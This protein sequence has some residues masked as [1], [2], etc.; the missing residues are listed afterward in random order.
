MAKSRTRVSQRDLHKRVK[1]ML[2]KARTPYMLYFMEKLP[3]IKSELKKQKLSGQELHRAAVSELGKRWNDLGPE[4]KELWQ[5]R[6]KAEF[7]HRHEATLSIASKSEPMPAV[8]NNCV[9]VGNWALSDVV[10]WQGAQSTAY[11]ATHYL[12]L[13]E[14]LAVLY[15]D[16][17]DFDSEV[18]M[19]KELDS[20]RAR[21]RKCLFLGIVQA[22]VENS[23][24]HCIIYQ[25]LP[26]IEDL[27]KQGGWSGRKLEVVGRQLALALDF[28][29][30]GVGVYHCNIRPKAVH[31]SDV[32]KCVK[33]SHMGSVRRCQDSSKL[34]MAP[35]V[36]NYR[37][38][39]LWQAL[40]A[41]EV[42]ELTESWAFGCT[43][44]EIGSGCRMFDTV[45]AI[46]NFTPTREKLAHVEALQR[47]GVGVAR[48]LVQFLSSPKERLCLKHFLASEALL[49]QLG[50]TTH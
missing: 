36:A 48:L 38:P 46:V 13:S 34:E 7:D 26:V 42:N 10:I 16:R 9:K 23:P 49:S 4:Q 12:L 20:E 50:E 18:A 22:V 47:L 24:L 6:S 40:E 14:A 41:C 19:L 5:E 45:Q 11:V 35:Y 31:W 3:E 30:V 28:L 8:M 33:L 17:R 32:E 43:M 21:E 29:H 15:K 44:I 1:S 2:P 25:P 27:L 37:A 39:E